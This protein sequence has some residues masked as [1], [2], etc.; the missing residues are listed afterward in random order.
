M[1][2]A[3]FLLSKVADELET[4]SFRYQLLG[5]GGQIIIE[6]LNELSNAIIRVLEKEIK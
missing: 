5:G 3:E 6:V 4:I 1:T 2:E